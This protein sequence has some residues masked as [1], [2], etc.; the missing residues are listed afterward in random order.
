V[1][2]NGFGTFDVR[3][4]DDDDDGDAKWEE[5]FVDVPQQSDCFSCGVFTLAFLRLLVNGCFNFKDFAGHFDTKAKI[6]QVRRFIGYELLS[7]KILPMSTAFPRAEMVH[8]PACHCAR[9]TKR[10]PDVQCMVHS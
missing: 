8:N 1:Q 7:G 5:V 6:L 3:E 10:G 2:Q 4:R 9:G